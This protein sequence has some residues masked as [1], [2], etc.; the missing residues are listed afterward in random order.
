MAGLAV[1]ASGST[2]AVA[3]D[4]LAAVGGEEAAKEF[5]VV[6]RVMAGGIVVGFCTEGMASV[7]PI[8]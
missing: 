4:M 2:I 7:H 6:L 5:V 3:G 1:V 8:S